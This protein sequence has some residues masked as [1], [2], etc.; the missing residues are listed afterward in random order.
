M[1]I[2]NTP[3]GLATTGLP[4]AFYVES[5]ATDVCIPRRDACAD[6]QRGEIRDASVEHE[7]KFVVLMLC[8]THVFIH[9]LC[10]VLCCLRRTRAGLL[11]GPF[12]RR[13]VG[14][15]P[16]AA[17]RTTPPARSLV[18]SLSIFP[19]TSPALSSPSST[20]LPH[21]PTSSSALVRYRA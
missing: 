13:L 20:F 11:L 16:Q 1:P 2:R 5:E 17:A 12:K 6:G 19:T 15:N 21:Q 3:C 18:P 8:N 7:C 10:H 9:V 14:A 4:G